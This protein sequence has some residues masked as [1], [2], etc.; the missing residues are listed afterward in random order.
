[1]QEV[2]VRFVVT[3]TD[4]AAEA[5][6]LVEQSLQKLFDRG[7]LRHAFTV[8]SDIQPDGINLDVEGRL[9]AEWPDADE[10]GTIRVKD[11]HG[12]TVECAKR[13]DEGVGRA[14]WEELRDLMP[15]DALYFQPEEAGD[16]DCGTSA[17]NI[18]SYDVYRNFD[19]AQKAHPDCEILAY[20]MSEIEEP[21]FLDVKEP[22]LHWN[23]P[24]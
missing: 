16:P 22:K 12:N 9:L 18:K 6:R 2:F 21:K 17:A 19:N 13:T 14:R 3:D 11:E 1:M 15:D 10:D 20:T 4:D 8:Q 24:E 5:R 23:K 7:T